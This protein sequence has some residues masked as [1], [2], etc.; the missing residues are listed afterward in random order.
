MILTV[1]QIQASI[2]INT[3][4]NT[5]KDCLH[6]VTEFFEVISKSVPHIYHSALQL[7]PQ[8]SIVRKLYHHSSGARVVTGIPVKWDLCAAS[9]TVKINFNGTVWSPCGQ[10]IVASCERTVQ[11]LDSNTL[12]RVF[13]L[14]PPSDLFDYTPGCLALSPD[15]HLL[16]YHCSK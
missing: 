6:F 4:L 1:G 3:L 16:A 8:S 9:A 7:A 12:E 15:G 11:V 13:S 2:D 10:F 14:E 5:A